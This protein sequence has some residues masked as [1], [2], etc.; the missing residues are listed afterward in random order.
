MRLC[1]SVTDKTTSSQVFCVVVVTFP[2][3]SVTFFVTDLMVFSV[4][5]TTS[6]QESVM[7]STVS[8]V[9]PS[10][11]SPP[12]VLPLPGFSPGFSLPPVLPPPGVTGS[13]YQTMTK[14][15]DMIHFEPE[16]EIIREKPE[17]TNYDFRDP[18]AIKIGEKYYIV[19]GR[20]QTAF[21]AYGVVHICAELL[22]ER[23]DRP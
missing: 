13:S 4:P 19:L 18:K 22:V 5:S 12:P 15:S 10:G 9:V 3:A 17:G 21:N 11:F 2:A 16:K 6:F 1:S 23:I 20:F 8:F 14:S 7:V